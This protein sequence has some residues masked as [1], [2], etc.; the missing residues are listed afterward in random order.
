MPRT[1]DWHRNDPNGELAAEAFKAYERW[2]KENRF[3]YQQPC[4]DPFVGRKYVWLENMRGVLAKYDYR[5]KK[6]VPPAE[7]RDGR[8]R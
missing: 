1:R 3:I 6:L 4:S 5:A 8:W 7:W 2:C